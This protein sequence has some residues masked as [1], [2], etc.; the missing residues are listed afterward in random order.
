MAKSKTEFASLTELETA[1][2]KYEDMA[3]NKMTGPWPAKFAPLA[4]AV[5]MLTKEVKSLK[6]EVAKLKRSA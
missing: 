4:A 1:M 5:L 2:T 6:T 3:V